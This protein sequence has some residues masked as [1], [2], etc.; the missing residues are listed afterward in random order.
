MIMSNTDEIALQSPSNDL[1]TSGLINPNEAGLMAPPPIHI[2][3][4]LLTMSL[5]QLWSGPL[6]EFI[7]KIPADW[8]ART[9]WEGSLILLIALL[10]FAVAWGIQHFL[11]KDDNKQAIVKALVLAIIVATPE[12]TTSGIIGTIFMA[13]SG[14]SQVRLNNIPFMQK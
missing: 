2:L 5:D 13:W 3:S 11:A 9:Y 6:P 8:T 10:M 4:A 12:Y 1:A 14:L 7:Q